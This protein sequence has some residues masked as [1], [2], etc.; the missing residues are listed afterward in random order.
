MVSESNQTWKLLYAE[1][2]EALE[3]GRYKLSIDKLQAAISQIPDNTFADGEAKI[4]LVTAYQAAGEIKQAVNLCRSL[5]AYPH[6][7]IST[8]AKR[9]LYIIE[10]PQLQRPQDWMSEIPDL[11]DAEPAE[12]VTFSSKTT[13]SKDLKA[14]ESDSLEVVGQQDNQ[15]VWAALGLIFLIIAG[16]FWFNAAV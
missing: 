7:V 3:R 4:L 11:S 1:G 10:A 8:Q 13:S 14:L 6:P 5:T 16:L 9:I 12:S 2:K 15:F